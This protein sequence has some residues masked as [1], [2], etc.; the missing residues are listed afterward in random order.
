MSS[1]NNIN[2]QIVINGP[3]PGSQRELP[4]QVEEREV[5]N[6]QVLQNTSQAA[7]SVLSRLEQGHHRM[8]VGTAKVSHKLLKKILLEAAPAVTF[9]IINLGIKLLVLAG[10]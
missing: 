2:I 5:A 6:Q 10:V 1:P 9:R 4:L 7:E 8:L 3:Q